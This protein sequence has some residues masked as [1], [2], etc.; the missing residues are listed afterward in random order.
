MANIPAHETARRGATPTGLSD[1]KAARIMIGLRGGG[2]L[3]RFAV[4]ASRFEAY[5]KAQPDYAREAKAL[6]SEN[7]QASNLRK[8]AAKRALTHCKYG[9]PLSGDNLYLAPAGK[10][11]NAG[12]V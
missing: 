11:A 3:R 9:H 4:K 2:T 1:E 10:S 8:G 6:L 12:R 7:L 5:C